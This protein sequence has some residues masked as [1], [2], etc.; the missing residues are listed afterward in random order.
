MR[1]PLLVW[2]ALQRLRALERGDLGEQAAT[3]L[4]ADPAQEVPATSV[5]R[6]AAT[7]RELAWAV[8]LAARLGRR[9]PTCLVRALALWSLLGDVGIAAWV[10]LGARVSPEGRLEAHAWVE[11]AGGPVAEAPDIEAHFPRLRG[12]LGDS[13]AAASEPGDPPSTRAPIADLN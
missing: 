12:P 4:R 8:S 1:R 9:R 6:G 5:G 11:V 10:R 13:A 2:K 3:A 7:V